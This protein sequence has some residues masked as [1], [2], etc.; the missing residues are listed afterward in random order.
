[1]TI[2]FQ[3][4]LKLALE[5]AQKALG[6]GNYPI[7]SVLV[8]ES[9]AVIGTHRNEVTTTHDITAH[10]EIACIRDIDN[11]I[12]DNK[13]QK[14]T[15]LFTSLEPC[16][17]CSFFIER[18]SITHVVRALTDPYKGGMS[19]IMESQ[20]FSSFFKHIKVTAEPFPDLAETSKRM[21]REYFLNNNREDMASFYS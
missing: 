11:S 12:I 2:D 1:M 20:E 5:E 15:I 7:G 14:Q 17:G 3:T 10:A 19:K 8:D 13:S 18:T 9:G 6:E 21:M 4:P 16:G